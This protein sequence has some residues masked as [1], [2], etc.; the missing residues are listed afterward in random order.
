[1]IP[2]LRYHILGMEKHAAVE[3]FDKKAPGGMDKYIYE[4]HV[5]NY[6]TT[7]VS[8]DL[9]LD[10]P[11]YQLQKLMSNLECSEKQVYDTEALCHTYY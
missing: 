4:D 6:P 2:S 10:N 5:G 3:E 9:T 11:L 8:G 7:I 1:M